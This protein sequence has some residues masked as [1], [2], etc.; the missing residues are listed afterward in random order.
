VEN[1]MSLI[2]SG[3]VVGGRFSVNRFVELVS[4][5]PAKL[6]GL[7][8]RKGTIAVGSDADLVIFNPTRKH[9]ISAKTH[10][11]RVDYSMFEGIQVTGMADMVLSRGKVIVE[12]EKFLG[13]AGQGQ[14]LRRSTYAQV[15]G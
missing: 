8:P 2:Y 9:T 7:Y 5:T 15:N 14:F 1:R 11:M 13:R 3:G 10:H 12:G 4:T 6:F